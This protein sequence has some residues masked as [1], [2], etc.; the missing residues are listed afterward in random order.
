MLKSLKNLLA[1]SRIDPDDIILVSEQV[2]EPKKPL[3]KRRQRLAQIIELN[4]PN[5]DFP[6]H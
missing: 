2:Q 3:F 5:D 6:T 4:E 1:W